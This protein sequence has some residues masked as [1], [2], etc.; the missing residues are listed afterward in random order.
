VKLL[1]KGSVP[2]VLEDSELRDFGELVEPL[3]TGVPGVPGVPGSE[4]PPPPH[5]ERA[6]RASM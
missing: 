1:K 3:A 6:N 2:I 4:S 5:A